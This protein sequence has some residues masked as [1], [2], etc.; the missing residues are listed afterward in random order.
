VGEILAV[1]GIVVLAK[2]IRSAKKMRCMATFF[3]GFIIWFRFFLSGYHEITFPPVVLGMSV[4]A[5]VS[6]LVVITAFFI[7]PLRL[8]QLKVL[9]P[10]YTF[11][12]CVVLSAVVNS[13][14][15]SSVGSIIKWVYLLIVSL[16]IYHTL[17][18]HGE[19]KV[20]SYLLIPFSL[21]IIMQVISIFLGYSKQT[22]GDMSISFIGGYNHEAV[23]S[24]I[25]LTFMVLWVLLPRNS[26]RF[27]PL[28]VGFSIF[29]LLMANYRTAL[30]GALPI[31]LFYYWDY[32]IKTVVQ[33]QRKYTVFFLVLFV[34][35]LAG[36]VLP[37][38]SERFGDIAIVVD[39]FGELL[40]SD[41]YYTRDERALFSARL[42]IWSQYLTDFF[43][44]P[45]KL[46]LT[47][48]GADSW[49]LSYDKYAH[50][51][52]VSFLYE[53]GFVGLL[54]FIWILFQPLKML[55][56]TP[57]S[58]I[59]GRLIAAHIGFIVVNMATMPL[60][61]IEGV[62][63]YGVLLGFSWFHCQRVKT[64]VELN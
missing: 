27:Q 1:V 21:P 48:F 38:F 43:S 11:L 64:G 45:V 17:K 61:Q 16:L 22:E 63:F 60:W 28:M 58:S 15:G 54:V 59:K 52:F 41:Q 46:W 36:V 33:T 53:F 23:F 25:I 29:C 5:L 47:G 57:P 35:G 34:V 32:S 44:A 55:L 10:V 4:N 3:L 26:I 13:Q 8:W 40:K 2:T 50:N 56:A 24:I 6:V 9:L 19:K 42:Y 49:K 12:L 51:T 20:L 37:I 14:F 7:V 18:L 31:L 62:M 39:S 30:L